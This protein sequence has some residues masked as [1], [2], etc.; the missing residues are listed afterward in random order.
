MQH[1]SLTGSLSTI[2]IVTKPIF[3]RIVRNCMHSKT[4]IE[5]LSFLDFS[6]GQ[7]Q[8]FKECHIFV[9]QVISLQCII[10]KVMWC[11]PHANIMHIKIL[12]IC[13]VSSCLSCYKFRYCH[14][15][16]SYFSRL[17]NKTTSD[18]NHRY[19]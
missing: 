6:I 8:V 11:Y 12:L 5:C 4:M 19:K 16:V 10:R 14:N 7:M 15:I 9:I 2:H 13:A 3:I 1:L 18:K 17:S